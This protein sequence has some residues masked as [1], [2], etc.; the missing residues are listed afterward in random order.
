MYRLRPPSSVAFGLTWCREVALRVLSSPV[1]LPIVSVCWSVPQLDALVLE[2]NE[3]LIHGKIKVLISTPDILRPWRETKPPEAYVSKLQDFANSLVSHCSI[4]LNSSCKL[5]T[6]MCLVF[7][8]MY[9]CRLGGL[10]LG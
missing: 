5:N 2:K 8:S 1:P 10:T 9:S 3:F 6:F 7:Q 4:H